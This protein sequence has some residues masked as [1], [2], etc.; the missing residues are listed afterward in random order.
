[1]MI[2]CP[3]YC[4]NLFNFMTMSMTRRTK[5]QAPGGGQLVGQGG[6]DQVHLPADRG[7]ELELRAG[8]ALREERMR[9]WLRV[10]G[11]Q[12]RGR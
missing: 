6:G 2:F 1:M 7:A 4:L 5:L 11:V 12:P 9:L 8:G 3:H 10:R